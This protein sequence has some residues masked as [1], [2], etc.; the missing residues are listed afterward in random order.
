MYLSLLVVLIALLLPIYW[1]LLL[2]CH[3]RKGREGQQSAGWRVIF[4]ASFI[5]LLLGGGCA[6]VRERCWERSKSVEI[7]L[8]GNVVVL[9]CPHFWN[10][11]LEHFY[12][13]ISHLSFLILWWLLNFLY[14]IQ[15][16]YVFVWITFMNSAIWIQLFFNS[17]KLYVLKIRCMPGD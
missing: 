16:F 4:Y 13:L 8:C 17:T 1:A 11:S 7:Q 12:Y 6:L 14:I 10:H 2:V 5:G 9:L 3:Q 15:V